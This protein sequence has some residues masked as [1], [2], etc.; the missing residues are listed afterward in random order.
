MTQRTKFLLIADKLYPQQRTESSREAQEIL[1]RHE[2]IPDRLV[3]I[4]TRSKHSVAE[5]LLAR[6]VTHSKN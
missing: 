5:R 2:V 3:T 1:K 4:Q 6:D